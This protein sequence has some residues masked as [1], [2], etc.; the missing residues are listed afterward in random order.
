MVIIGDKNIKELTG[1]V[2]S[3]K[4]HKSLVIAVERVKNHPLYRKRYTITKKYYAHD[5]N[6]EAHEG[7]IVRIRE[8]KPMSKL[9]RWTLIEIVKK[10]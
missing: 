9:K 10:A 5:E 2:V 1:K 8:T 7:D 3:A 4:M 6:S